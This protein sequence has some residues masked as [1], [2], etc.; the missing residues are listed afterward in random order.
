MANPFQQKARQRKLIYAVLIAFLFTGSL[1]HRRLVVEP[2]ANHLQ[3]R[4]QARGE[5]E[6]TSSAVRQMLT[7][8]KGMA[9]TFLWSA[10][11][12]KQK[13]NEWNELEL[14]VNSITKLQPYFI[15]PWLY[16]SWN[17]SFNVAVECDLPRDKYY[18]I[19]RGLELL[20]EGERRNQG[21][22]DT[23]TPDPTKP[24]F[25]GHPELRHYMGFTYQL[26]IGN[27]D[28]KNTMRSLFEMSCIDPVKRNAEALWATNERGQRDV[29]LDR[30]REFVEKNPRLVRRLREKLQLNTPRQVVKFLQD[31]ADIPTRFKKGELTADQRESQLLDPKRQFPILPP[32]LADHWPDPTKQDLNADRLEDPIDVFLACKTWYEYAQKPLPPPNPDP[33]LKE[34][35]YDRLRYRNAKQ[36]ASQIFRGYPARGQAYIAENLEAEG[37]FDGEGW[38]VKDWFDRSRGGSADVGPVVVGAEGRATRPGARYGKLNAGRAW[39]SAYAMYKE[40]GIANGL[41]LSAGEVQELN[42]KAELV[43]ERFKVKPDENFTL[44]SDLHTGALGASYDA[45]QKLFWNRHYRSMTNYD[46]HLYQAEGE[47]DPLTVHARKLLYQADRLRR[48]E[49]APDEALEKFQEAWPLWIAACIR[50]PRFAKIGSVQEDAYELEMKYL[51]LLQDQNPRAF[52]TAFV[53]ASHLAQAPF[54]S[55]APDAVAAAPFL[56][57]AQ[58]RTWPAGS[59]YRELGQELMYGQQVR[60]LPIRTARGILAETQFYDVNEPDAV[61]EFLLAWTKATTWTPIPAPGEQDFLL[62]RTALANAPPPPGWQPIVRPESAQV[63]RDRLGLKQ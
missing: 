20:A 47:R 23:F 19:S 35:D 41:Y 42:R 38:L 46:D 62:T 44:R 57:A 49:A 24:Q 2:Q 59:K 40:Y 34:K 29:D 37:W 14:L 25:P 55:P 9:V 54:A 45:H 43:R 5:V 22:G 16:Q 3:L 53:A 18:Y 63:V 32:A 58:L 26:K 60:V 39:D 33:G 11:I 15:T 30:F 6:L 17:L 10:A 27:P 21:S 50:N 12:E 4:E 48:F 56:L 52:H 61:R 51:R 31:N 8:S 7:G 1:L 36:M 13:K 28:E